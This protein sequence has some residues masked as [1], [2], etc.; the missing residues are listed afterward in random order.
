[1]DRGIARSGRKHN[2]ALPEGATPDGLSADVD[3]SARWLRR[4]ARLQGVDSDYCIDVP[5]GFDDSDDEGQVHPMA[6]R[7]FVG[8]TAAEVF[9]KVQH[10]VSQHR[11]FL[12]DVSWNRLPDEP[13]PFM[14]SVYFTFERDPDAEEQE[15]AG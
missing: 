3:A 1:V 9:A 6:R 14:L 13:Q 5:P 15:P 11:V 7:L 10:W 4:I 8:H 2:I 12:V